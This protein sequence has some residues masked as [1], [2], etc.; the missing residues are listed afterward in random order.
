MARSACN[1]CG[2]RNPA[3]ETCSTATELLHWK[4][5]GWSMQPETG[6]F[7]TC[8]D[9]AASSPLWRPP[10][11]PSMGGAGTFWI[12]VPDASRRGLD[13]YCSASEIPCDGDTC[14]WYALRHAMCMSTG[15]LV[16]SSEEGFVGGTGHRN[17]YAEIVL[18][19]YAGSALQELFPKGEMSR[20]VE[21]TTSDVKWFYEQK[22]WMDEK[23]GKLHSVEP[24]RPNAL[25]LD[26]VGLKSL[27]RQQEADFK[28]GRRSCCSGTVDTEAT[29][30]NG[31]FGSVN[32]L[33]AR[34]GCRL[35]ESCRRC[36]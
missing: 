3:T 10:A 1:L 5:G 31:S 24:K 34:Q 27:R 16:D 14:L 33:I 26:E 35:K 8:A 25:R 6:G 15:A 32:E 4:D 22:V 30:R 21:R 36:A 11:Y 28:T 20:F 12:K 7:M 23:L 2:H 13:L 17:S 29:I 19:L 18:S 9:C